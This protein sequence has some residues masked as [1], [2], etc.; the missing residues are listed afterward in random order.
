[1]A[2]NIKVT[3]ACKKYW[4]AVFE[5]LDA[6][7]DY[8][9]AVKLYAN[10]M[11]QTTAWKVQPIFEDY[12]EGKISNLRDAISYRESQFYAKVN[13]LN[14]L[15]KQHNI[16]AISKPKRLL[17]LLLDPNRRR[18]YREKATRRLKKGKICPM[19]DFEKKK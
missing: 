2:E 15:C 7:G 5:V 6:A 8:S 1:M 12:Y 11:D 13:K 19:Q 4:T 18:S 9:A 17:D 3:E 16:M 10:L 14:I